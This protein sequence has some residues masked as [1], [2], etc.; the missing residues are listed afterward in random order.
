MELTSDELTIEI[1]KDMVVVIFEAHPFGK[2]Y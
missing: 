2:L 1:F